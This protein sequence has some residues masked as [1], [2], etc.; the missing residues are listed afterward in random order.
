MKETEK[1]HTQTENMEQSTNSLLFHNSGNGNGKRMLK[2]ISLR[3]AIGPYILRGCGPTTEILITEKKS[4]GRRY[5]TFPLGVRV[6][7][8]EVMHIVRHIWSHTG[9]FLSNHRVKKVLG[10]VI[11]VGI[12][13]DGRV[14][15]QLLDGK[16]FGGTY[17]ERMN[18]E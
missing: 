5:L 13:G 8:G 2:K 18:S 10:K 16:F 4:D 17:V 7:T 9:V 3:I 15:V 11:V 1:M 12:V 14:E 6:T